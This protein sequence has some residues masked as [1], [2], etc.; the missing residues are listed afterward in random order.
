MLLVTLGAIMGLVRWWSARESVHWV[1]ASLQLEFRRGQRVIRLFVEDLT[2][3]HT[4]PS[5]ARTQLVAGK[6]TYWLS[7]KLI[8]VERLLDYLRKHRSD[9]VP[10]PGRLQL[11]VSWARPLSMV[12]LAVGTAWTGLLLFE[13]TPWIGVVFGVGAGLLMLRIL[14]FLP[15]AYLVEPQRLRVQYWLR[16][17]TRRGSPSIWYESYAAGGAEFFRMRLKYGRTE[18][19]LDE[20]HLR[21]SLRPWA[22]LIR[23][24]LNQT[25]G[26]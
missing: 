21:D 4:N 12:L 8:G 6:K 11:H 18:V 22:T 13:W 15:R 14:F 23:D 24:R 1:E 17:R 2:R 25:P 3:I 9:L 16:W 5:A 7:H 20:G 26:G 19:N 10:V